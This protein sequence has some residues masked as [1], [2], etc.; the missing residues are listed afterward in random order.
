MPGIKFNVPQHVALPP[1]KQG[2]WFL[3]G[4]SALAL[5]LA[6]VGVTIAKLAAW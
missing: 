6:F 3:L 4:M 2:R 1:E 5:A